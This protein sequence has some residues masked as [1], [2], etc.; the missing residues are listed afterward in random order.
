MLV[1]VVFAIWFY[2]HFRVSPDYSAL[3]DEEERVSDGW[4]REHEEVGVKGGKKGA[5]LVMFRQLRG[6]GESVDRGG[7]EGGEET[8]ELTRLPS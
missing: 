8:R 6:A 5:G 2:R 3:W 7:M 1:L 4:V